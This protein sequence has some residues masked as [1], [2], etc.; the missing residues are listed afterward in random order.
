VACARS[1]VTSIATWSSSRCARPTSG[2]HTPAV[3][4]KRNA[5]DPT[6]FIQVIE[7]QSDRAVELTRQKLAS[8]PITH[9]FVQAWRSLFSGAV[10]VDLY[11]DV[12][13]TL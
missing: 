13:E 11:E 12:T 6:Q 9:N 2:D 8:D 3:N 5:D 10:D 7:Y 4:Q 1:W